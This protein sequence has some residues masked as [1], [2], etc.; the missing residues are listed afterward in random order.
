MEAGTGYHDHSGSPRWATKP[1][2][3]ESLGHDSG[4]QR[5]EE[6]LQNGV[7]SPKRGLLSEKVSALLWVASKRSDTFSEGRSA[8]DP[9]L[10]GACL[11]AMEQ[12][13]ENSVDK[14][15]AVFI[16]IPPRKLHRFIDGNTTRSPGDG[17]FIGS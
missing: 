14:T 3:I 7:C 6:T 4:T 17:H 15:G 10:G 5:N 2:S 13:V 11:Q 1:T 16:S 8:S 12:F 9:A